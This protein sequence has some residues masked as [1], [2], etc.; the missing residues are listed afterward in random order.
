MSSG[1][2]ASRQIKGEKVEAM[3]D[4]NLMGSKITTEIKRHLLLEGKSMTKLVSVLKS[5]DINLPTK[6][7]C[8]QRYGFSSSH[9]WMLEL[10][11]KEG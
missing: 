3:T 6:V 10:D 4:L 5:R 7:H 11:H 8:S 9:V 2:K 1:P